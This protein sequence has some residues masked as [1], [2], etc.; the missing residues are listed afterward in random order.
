MKAPGRWLDDPAALPDEL[1][2]S[3]EAYTQLG[4]SAHQLARVRAGVQPRALAPVALKVL[5]AVALAGGLTAWLGWPPA[6]PARSLPTSAPVSA[7]RAAPPPE[8][9]AAVPVAPAPEATAPKKPR[10]KPKALPPPTQLA[11]PAGELKLLQRARRAVVVAPEAALALAE[12]HARTYP[13][14]DFAEERELLAIEALS[15]TDREAAHARARA[16]AASYPHSVHAARIQV[17]LGDH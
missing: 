13:Q 2:A 4:P 3:M 5:A 15:H 9:P 7:P 17:L 1:R 16:F 6:Q 14:G 11:D 12:E 8:Q 10:A